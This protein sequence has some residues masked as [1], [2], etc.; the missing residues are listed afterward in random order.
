MA[1]ATGVVRADVDPRAE[2]VVFLGV[3]R[4]VTM[5]W[6]LDPE[7]VDIVAALTQYGATLDRTLGVPS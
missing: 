2:A 3:L 6:L 1:S 7:R 5:Q 4:G